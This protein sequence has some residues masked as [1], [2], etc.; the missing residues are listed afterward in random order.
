MPDAHPTRTVGSMRGNFAETLCTTADAGPDRRAV[1]DAAGEWS[2]AELRRAA[3]AVAHQLDRTG[4]GAN[5]RVAIF[6]PRGKEA[7]NAWDPN[8]QARRQPR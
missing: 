6:L 7:V 3:A 2:Y 8:G 5:D 1:V 4:V